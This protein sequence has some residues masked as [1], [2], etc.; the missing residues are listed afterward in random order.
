MGISVSNDPAK[1]IRQPPVMSRPDMYVISGNPDEVTAQIEAFA[2]IGV[3]HMQLNFLDYPH[4]D[5]LDLFLSVSSRASPASGRKAGSRTQRTQSAQ[6][7][8][9]N[10]RKKRIVVLYF[11]FVSLC[12]LCALCVF[13][14]Q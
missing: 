3:R 8:A 7:S 2:A 14:V 13:A 12:V 10:G 4:T 1:L 6:R 11:I 5:G 9:K